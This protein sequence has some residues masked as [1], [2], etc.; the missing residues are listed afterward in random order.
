MAEGGVHVVPPQQP[1]H[2]AAEP[3]AFRVAGW[4]VNHAGGF[5][6]LV[7]PALGLLGGVGRLRRRRLV[8]VLGIAALGKSQ[9]SS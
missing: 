4:P 2:P 9:A 1:D 8:A 5:G 6:E 7:D 3:N